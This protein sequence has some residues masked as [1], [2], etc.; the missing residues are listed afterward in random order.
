M[1][2]SKEQTQTMALVALVGLV[3]A[4]GSYMGMIKP[5]LGRAAKHKESVEEWTDELAKQRR[6]L[7]KNLDTM[8]RAEAI[9]ARTAELEGHIRHGLF[10]GRLTSCFEELRRTHGFHFRFQHDLEQIEP[11]NAGQYHELSNRFTVLSCD[12]YQLI[13]FIQVLETTNP[14]IRVSNLEVRAHD[15]DQP[16][17]RVDAQI[18]LRLVGFKDGRDDPWESGSEDTFKPERRNP[19]CPPGMRGADPNASMREKLGA[20]C[21]N[22]TIGRGALLRPVPDAA[23]ELVE[24]GEH[25]PCLDEKV[26]L[27]RYSNRALLVCHEPTRTYYKLTLYTSGEQAGQVERVEEITQR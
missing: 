27:V 3:I 24:A 9:E 19:F 20:I 4:V 7:K 10:A 23:A 11:L 8:H 5:N 16:D 22:G 17:G 18:E 12:F 25:L 1:S 13:R 15:A 14:G 21:F 26:R 2:Y 6:I